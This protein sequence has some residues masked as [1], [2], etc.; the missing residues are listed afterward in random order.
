MYVNQNVSIISN[1]CQI[2]FSVRFRVQSQ[3]SLLM[4]YSDTTHSTFQ[5]LPGI[6]VGLARWG[7]GG[8]RLRARKAWYRT[9]VSLGILKTVAVTSIAR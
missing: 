8:A 1:I 9:D 2:Y 6:S 4:T 5:L 3:I 7:G